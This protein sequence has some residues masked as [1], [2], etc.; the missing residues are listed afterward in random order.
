MSKYENPEVKKFNESEE[1]RFSNY[2]NKVIVMSS[3]EYFRME[4]NTKEKEEEIIY[5]YILEIMEE[6]ISNNA[7]FE[8]VETKLELHKGLKMLSAIEQSVIFLLFSE[9]LSQ[10]EASQ[11]L[12]ICS[13]SVSR[14]KNR[15]L[16]KLKE[17][18]EEVDEDEE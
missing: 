4:C 5:K 7:C 2:L 16:R 6:I 8:S 18:I 13:K 17:F 3:K 12:K 10:E 15:A 1:K 11:I 9:D 14:I